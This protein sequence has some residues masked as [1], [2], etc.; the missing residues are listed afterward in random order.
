MLQ[1]FAFFCLFSN[2]LL[3]QSKIEV[4]IDKG[5]LLEII[6]SYDHLRAIFFGTRNINTQ[7]YSIVYNFFKFF[8]NCSH[9]LSFSALAVKQPPERFDNRLLHSF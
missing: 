4:K 6:T 3:D 9:I 1:F 7:I 5:L 8:E 2:F